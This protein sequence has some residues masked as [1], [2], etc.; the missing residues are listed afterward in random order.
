MSTQSIHRL[1]TEKKNQRAI[2]RL[3]N[4]QFES[5]TMQP[6]TGFYGGKPEASI[7]VEIVGAKGAEIRALA[8]KIRRMNG[9]KSV[10][11]IEYRAIAKT[12]R[13]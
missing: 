5:F 10:L 9:Q 2:I 1:Y 4:E 11:T 8:E 6:V 12:V 3:I 7:V 13:W